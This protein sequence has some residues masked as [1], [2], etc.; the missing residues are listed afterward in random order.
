[1]T[2]EELIQAFEAGISPAGG[3]HHEQHV[4]AAWW[5]LQPAA[6]IDGPDTAIGT[7]A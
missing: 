3:F 1:M 2:D 7:G 6:A 4:R 5:Y